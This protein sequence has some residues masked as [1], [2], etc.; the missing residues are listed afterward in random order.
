[1]SA[2][3]DHT[4]GPPEATVL[5]LSGDLDHDSERRLAE[6]VDAAAARSTGLLVL[7]VAAVTFADSSVLRT[8]VLAQQRMEAEAGALVLLGP[9]APALRRLLEIT[10]TDG[11]FTVADSLPLARAAAADLLR[12]RPHGTGTG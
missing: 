5:R 4:P 3:T 12:R 7:D 9:L 10:A 2:M 11:Y 8:L 6:A 1:M